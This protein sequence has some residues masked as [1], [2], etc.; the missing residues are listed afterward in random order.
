MKIKILFNLFENVKKL[1]GLLKLGEFLNVKKIRISI[2]AINQN[3][4]PKILYEN[5]FDTK[6]ADQFAQECQFTHNVLA[7][8]LHKQSK[9]VR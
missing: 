1:P 3:N 8:Y 5:D 6:Q 4:Q 9:G 7:T 2:S